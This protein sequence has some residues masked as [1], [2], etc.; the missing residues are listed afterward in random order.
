MH[1]YQLEAFGSRNARGPFRVT[2]SIRTINIRVVVRPQALGIFQLGKPL[3]WLVDELR[4]QIV[5]L[6][7]LC[8]LLAQ[9]AP[10][11]EFQS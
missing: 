6:E 11:V 4:G 9:D 5:T 1:R 7:W 8:L 3:L 2:I 10:V